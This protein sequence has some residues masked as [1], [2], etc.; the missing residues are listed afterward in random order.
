MMSG[1]PARVA[2]GRLWVSPPVSGHSRAQYTDDDED[3]DGPGL[4]PCLRSAGLPSPGCGPGS[5]SLV[6]P[7]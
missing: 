3:D 2:V 1:R 4:A 7:R 6:R 5:G